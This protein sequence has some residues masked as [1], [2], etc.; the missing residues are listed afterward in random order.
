MGQ[1]FHLVLFSNLA[2]VDLLWKGDCSQARI[3]SLFQLLHLED[4]W[5][6]VATQEKNLSQHFAHLAVNEESIYNLEARQFRPFFGDQPCVCVVIFDEIINLSFILANRKGMPCRFTFTTFIVWCLIDFIFRI[7]SCHLPSHLTWSHT[8]TFAGRR[9]SRLSRK[10]PGSL[11]F[12]FDDA[13]TL[14]SFI[15]LSATM[16][17]SMWYDGCD[18][19]QSRTIN[20]R[21]ACSRY[22]R[23]HYVT[24][25]HANNP[26][27]FLLAVRLGSLQ[28]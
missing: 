5:Q 3:F 16:A 6:P 10:D 19:V 2:F 18:I 24:F 26:H 17:L 13:C 23:E 25:L 4:M 1:V 14:V 27:L 12:C 20:N 21:L 22:F 15:H 8:F 9:N 11:G 28:R 7:T